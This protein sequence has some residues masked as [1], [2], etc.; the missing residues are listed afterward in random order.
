[1]SSLDAFSNECSMFLD[2]MND[3]GFDKEQ[4]HYIIKKMINTAIRET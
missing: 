1:M 4:Q 3:I 2:M